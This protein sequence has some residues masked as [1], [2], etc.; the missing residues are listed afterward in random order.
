MR[1]DPI[2]NRDETRTERVNDTTHRALVQIVRA[3]GEGV[4]TPGDRV[5]MPQKDHS[6]LYVSYSENGG[7]IQS[8]TKSVI[9]AAPGTTFNRQITIK[10]TVIMTNCFIDCFENEPGII[11]EDTGRLIL[12]G[13]HITKGDN[14]QTAATDAYIQVNNGGYLVV[15]DCVFHG[16]QSNIGHLVY[17]YGNVHN[18]AVMSSIDLSDIAAPFHNVHHVYVVP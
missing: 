8:E 18:A 14:K 15:S 11:V 3:L 16:E 13:C 7:F 4:T 5:E 12:R 6:G 17:N 10:G 2:L 1:N 9:T